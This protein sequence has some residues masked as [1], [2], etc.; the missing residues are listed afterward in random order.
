LWLAIH[1]WDYN[2]TS[3]TDPSGFTNL[4][5]E[6][7][8]STSGTGI[9]AAYKNEAS[10]TV[11]PGSISISYNDTWFAHTIVIQPYAEEPY[12]KVYVNIGGTWKAAEGMWINVGGVWKPITSIGV[13]I[14]NIW[15]SSG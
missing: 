5:Y 9:R 3:S 10:A 11:D 1:G 6:R 14:G 7:N 13:N 12:K 2:R 4:E 15:K 8:T